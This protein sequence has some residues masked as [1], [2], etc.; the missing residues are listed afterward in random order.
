MR[1]LD[2]IYLTQSEE[3]CWTTSH[4]LFSDILQPQSEPDLRWRCSSIGCSVASEPEPSDTR[5]SP[6]LHVLLLKRC[7]LGLQQWLCTPSTGVAV[8]VQY[9]V[10]FGW[11]Y[12]NAWY[13]LASYPGS[14]W[15]GK[16]RAWYPL[17]VHALNFSEILGD[18]ELSSYICTTVT[19]ITCTNYYT[20]HTF[21][22]QWWSSFDW[23]RDSHLSDAA[24]SG[25]FLW[26]I[27]LS[28]HHSLFLETVSTGNF[29][30]AAPWYTNSPVTIGDYMC[31]HVHIA[32]SCIIL[33][34]ASSLWHD[35]I[36]T[37]ILLL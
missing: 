10:G 35:I 17:F 32:R 5:V 34:V 22:D 30:G 3:V 26:T 14:Q 28:P 19:F 27:F 4:L 13:S 33:I 18:R 6:T 21:S 29:M 23:G 1:Y 12:W 16:I 31:A 37:V 9:M 20:A 7:T 2:Q 36:Y 25:Y 24:F 8:P 15:A 11:S